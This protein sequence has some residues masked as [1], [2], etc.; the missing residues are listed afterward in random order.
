[1]EIVRMRDT[2]AYA[3][4]YGRLADISNLFKFGAPVQKSAAYTLLASDSGQ[5]FHDLTNAV[6]FTL[7]STLPIGWWA[8]FKHVANTTMTVAGSGATINGAASLAADNTQDPSA[9][10]LVI[11]TSADDFTAFLKG[12]WA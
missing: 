5:L 4:G 2:P 11:K 8:V 6:T 7:L 10:M 3:E 12:T 1:M 9:C